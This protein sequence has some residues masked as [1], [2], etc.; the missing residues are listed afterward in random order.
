M[1]YN[2]SHI[3][4]N[5]SSATSAAVSFNNTLADGA[6]GLVIIIV[7]FIVL[8]SGFVIKTGDP[9]KSFLASSWICSTIGIL[10]RIVGLVNDYILFGI[11]VIAAGALAITWNNR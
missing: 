11:I 7:L 4:G 6:I 2:F 5:M 3:T 1:I 9:S 10:F 8:F